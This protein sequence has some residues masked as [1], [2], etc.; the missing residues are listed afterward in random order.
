MSLCAFTP[1]CEA[2]AHWADQYLA[3][4]ERLQIPFFIYLDR[5]SEK[6]IHKLTNHPQCTGSV[7][8][9]DPSIEYNERA[10]QAI[11]D[12]AV[13]AGYTWTIHWDSDETWEKDFSRKIDMVL[14]SDLHCVTCRW[15]NLWNDPKHI[16]VDDRFEVESRITGREKFYRLDNVNW[17][18]NS[19]IVYG[20][21]PDRLVRRGAVDI[22][23][24]HWGYMTRELR[25]EHKAR[26]DHNY[27]KAVGHQPYGTWNY[28]CDESRVPTIV[29]NPYL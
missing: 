13:Q 8:Q 17:Q 14:D 18:F 27:T 16:R 1:I 15:V 6:T 19:G 20:P 29:S 9:D 22:A 10:K 12:M 7:R 2:D 21:S 25:L 28:I 26:W 4:I 24:L 11:L 23:C 5:C 3:E